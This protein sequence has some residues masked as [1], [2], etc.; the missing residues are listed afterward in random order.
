MGPPPARE[1]SRAGTG[2]TPEVKLR[3]VALKLRLKQEVGEASV[4]SSKSA[5]SKPAVSCVP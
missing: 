3:P 2:P 1:V 4:A 5:V